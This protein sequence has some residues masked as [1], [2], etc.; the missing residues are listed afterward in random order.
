MEH[1]MKTNICFSSFQLFLIPDE[2]TLILILNSSLY[3]TFIWDMQ[4]WIKTLILK[5]CKNQQK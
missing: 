5:I 1:K 4:A 2:A 3:F